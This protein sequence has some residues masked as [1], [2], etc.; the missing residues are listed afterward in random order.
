VYSIHEHSFNWWCYTFGE[1]LRCCR[2]WFSL[3]VYCVVLNTVELQLLYILKK[4][5]V[6]M[7]RRLT[8]PLYLCL[9]LV[10]SAHPTPIIYTLPLSPL[11]SKLPLIPQHVRMTTDPVIIRKF[12]NTSNCCQG[13]ILIINYLICG[14][15]N[16]IDS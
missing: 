2:D 5:C 4:G 1:L 9:F 16:I 14:C 13:M 10:H 12:M 11:E 15:L 3:R 6:T 8:L 7:I